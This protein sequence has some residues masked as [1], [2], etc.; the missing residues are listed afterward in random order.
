MTHTEP[1][2]VIVWQGN[3]IT[4]PINI[5]W[6]AALLMEQDMTLAHHG[7]GPHSL[8]GDGMAVTIAAA[9]SCLALPQG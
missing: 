1:I 5:S 2:S 6:G 7:A 3:N 4:E 8:P 9:G